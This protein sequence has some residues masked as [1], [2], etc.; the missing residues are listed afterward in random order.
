VSADLRYALRSF[1]RT[2]IFTVIAVATLALGIGATTA[3]F[4]VVNTLI[5]RPLPYADP[6]RLAL[7]REINPNGKEN[8]S[9]SPGNFLH[10]REIATSFDDMAAFSLAF[11]TTL[12]GAGEPEEMPMQYVS[13]GAFPILGVAPEIGRT[14]RLTK[15]S[16]T[17]PAL[18]C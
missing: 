11:R 16:R 18:S 7:I 17:V 14:L 13:A 2:P 3:I 12:S 10:W 6:A 4:S 15:T 9:G 5:L 8:P 1:A